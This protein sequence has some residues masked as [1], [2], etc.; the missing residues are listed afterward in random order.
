V[1]P[2]ER[3]TREDVLAGWFGGCI[4]YAEM[5]AVMAGGP[6]PAGLRVV[7]RELRK[8]N[9]R[10]DAMAT[11]DAAVDVKLRWD[12]RAARVLL[13]HDRPVTAEAA[14]AADAAVEGW[15]RGAWPALHLPPGVRA[16]VYGVPRAGGAGLVYETRE[17]GGRHV[18]LEAPDLAALRELIAA[19]ERPACEIAA[20]AGALAAAKLPAGF[21]APPW[22]LTSA[23]LA[24]A[25]AAAAKYVGE[26][27]DPPLELPPRPATEVSAVTLG[28]P[29]TGP[30][31]VAAADPPPARPDA[32]ACACTPEVLA[33]WGRC[34]CG[35]APSPG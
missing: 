3:P 33:A 32:P 31:L 29:A 30:A 8:P 35:A 17:P 16:E 21:A 15:V 34:R 4:T 7:P 28:P 12:G 24:A 11:N 23:E 14:A 18:R 1:T 22:V 27:F 10:G 6:V 13:Y 5:E 19:V 25:E 9:L 26:A 20:P 2:T